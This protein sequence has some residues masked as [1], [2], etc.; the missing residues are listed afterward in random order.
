MDFSKID[1]NLIAGVVSLLGTLA[2][3][4]YGK[5]RGS[6]QRDLSELLDET[7][8]AEVEDA[9]EDGETLDTIE[10]RLTQAAHALAKKLGPK[11]GEQT[12]RLAV[13]WGVIEFRKLVKK[14]ADNQAAVKRIP[15]QLDDL[16]DKAKA[17]EDAFVPKGT[18]P[19]L[20]T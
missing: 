9:L 10:D 18:F 2:A 1:P 7:I 20:K 8:T 13:T 6:K 14:R 4:V 11:V 3:W 16:A 17:V 15:G 5:A 19:K 12:L